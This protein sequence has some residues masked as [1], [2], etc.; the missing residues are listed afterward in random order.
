MARQKNSADTS[1]APLYQALRAAL[2][3]VDAAKEALSL[4]EEERAAAVT[5]LVEAGAKGP[6]RVAGSTVLLDVRK[7]G[8]YPAAE[9]EEKPRAR[10][11]VRPPRALDDV[12]EI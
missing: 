4:A 5:A 1:R 7:A 8:E 6:F 10:Y 11:D 2:A 9:G 12:T 3:T